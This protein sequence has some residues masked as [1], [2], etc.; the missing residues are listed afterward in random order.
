MPTDELD[1]DTGDH[2]DV[3]PELR[4][5]ER[6]MGKPDSVGYRTNWNIAYNG[7]RLL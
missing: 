2:E 3:S 5:Y 4:E 1:E 7:E 6:S